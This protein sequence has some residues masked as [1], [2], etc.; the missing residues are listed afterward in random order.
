MKKDVEQY[1]IIQCLDELESLNQGQMPPI[2]S[3]WHDIALDVKEDRRKRVIVRLRKIDSNSDAYEQLKN[4]DSEE[5][6]D[7][8]QNIPLIIMD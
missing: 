3:M 7:Y 8:V 1:S 4:Q 2:A 5:I 6:K